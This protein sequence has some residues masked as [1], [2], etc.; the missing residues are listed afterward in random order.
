MRT[1]VFVDGENL[2]HSICDLFKPVFDRRDYL[3]K[4][5]DW[6]AFF[7]HLV[8]K[9]TSDQGDRL[10][11]YWY[12]VQQCDPYPRPLA[13]KKR[14]LPE[15]EAWYKRNAKLLKGPHSVPAAGPARH[16]KLLELQEDLS[17][18]SQGIRSRFDG[19]TAIQNGIAQKHRAIEFRRSGAISH[20]LLTG[21]FGQE[22]Q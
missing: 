15:L 3:P 8:L 20:N 12:V 19:F 7:D 5:A 22:K 4:A 6:T 17:T 2:R 16:A 13:A 14:T 10:R 18:K 11:T 1:C 9:A 21:Q